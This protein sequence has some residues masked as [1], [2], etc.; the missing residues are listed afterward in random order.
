MHVPIVQWDPG[1][2]MEVL[3]LISLRMM[4]E[5]LSRKV[6]NM[7][8]ASPERK[9][10]AQAEMEAFL[11][12]DFEAL[13]P[14]EQEALLNAE[15][16]RLRS[17]IDNERARANDDETRIEE[18]AAEQAGTKGIDAARE[19]IRASIDALRKNAD[20]KESRFEEL[21]RGRAEITLNDKLRGL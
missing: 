21:A 18:L 19:E 13:K 10:A 3:A 17:S 4:F 12:R 20:A 5:G 7:L 15:R 16:A 2:T 1:A 11:K 9:A 6:N 8:E 14:E